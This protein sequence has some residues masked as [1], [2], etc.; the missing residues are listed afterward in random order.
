MRIRLREKYAILLGGTTAL[1]IIVVCAL[2]LIFEQI[3]SNRLYEATSKSMARA[4]EYQMEERGRNIVAMLREAIATPL[5]FEDFEKLYDL[6]SAARGL[7]GVD[8]L[9]LYDSQGKVIHDGTRQIASYGKALPAELAARVTRERWLVDHQ[10]TSLLIISPV[11]MGEA[12]IG[13]ISLQLDKR[14][15]AAD[16]KAHVREL[17]IFTQGQRQQFIGTVAVALPLLLILSI[18]IG[19]RLARHYSQPIERLQNVARRVAAGASNIDWPPDRDDELGDLALSLNRMVTSLRSTTVSMTYLDEIISSMFDCLVVTGTDGRIEK[20]N[21][22]T[23]RMTGYQVHELLNQPFHKLLTP[24]DPESGEPKTAEGGDVA[25]APD[26]AV[27]YTKSGRAIPV[28]MGSTVMGSHV[29]GRPREIRVFR[30]ISLQK[31]REAEL[32]VAKED[33]EVASAAKSRFLANMSHE[34]RTPLNAII[35]FSSIIRD[36]LKGPVSDEY[37]TYA[38]DVLESAEHLL[39]IIND[40]LDISKLEAGK[41]ELHEDEVDLDEV[42]ETCLRITGHKAR[43]RNITIVRTGQDRLPLVT[44]DQ[45]MV[46]QMLIN[47]LSNAVKFNVEGGRIELQ[48]SRC[49]TGELLLAVHDS[50]IGMRADVIPQVLEPFAQADSDLNRNYEGTGLGLAITKSM[51]ELHGGRI[52]IESTLGKGTS[53][54]LVFPSGRVVESM[55]EV[56]RQN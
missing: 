1:T 4:L 48:T 16:I 29:D 39:S 13:V 42:I 41:M 37:K 47:L 33:A 30:D 15:I 14:S 18:L 12:I 56:S 51:I 45:R 11:T 3:S 50:G 55:D 17:E 21:K 20:V 44:A 9:L 54:T 49:D 27:I 23:C 25:K 19:L 10:P 36:G 34:L 52:D 40:L 53:V 31:Q 24:P 26:E 22:A 28:Q 5:Y 8:A 2:F 7:E 35:G 6:L 43:E 38:K 46:K 32:Q